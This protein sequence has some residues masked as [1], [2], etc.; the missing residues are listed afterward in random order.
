LLIAIHL[1]SSLPYPASP[2]QLWYHILVTY[3]FS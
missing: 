3:N 2:S 1:L